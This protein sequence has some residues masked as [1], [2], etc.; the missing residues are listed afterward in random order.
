MIIIDHAAYEERT[1]ASNLGLPEYSYTFVRRSFR[2]ILE[3]LG[4]LHSV[5]DPARE[6][7]AIY[8]DARVRGEPC[9]FLSFNP[10][11]YVPLELEC[12]TVPVFAWEYDTI[13][14]EVWAANPQD[15]WR[16]PLL[17]CGSAIT[18]CQSSVRAVRAAMGDHYPIWSIPA[19][20]FSSKRRA[21]SAPGWPNAS[22]LVVDGAIVIDTSIVDVGIFHLD[23]VD[24][25][26]LKVLRKLRQRARANSTAT[27]I[28]LNEVVYTAI[29]NPADGRKNWIDLL[30]GFI[31][32]FRGN[33]GVTLIVKITQ[34]DMLAGL[35]PVLTFLARQGAFQCRIVVIQGML[36]DSAYAALI[37][38][39]SYIVN[40]SHGEGQCLPLMEFMSAGRPAIAPH[41]SAMTEYITP[42]NAFM[43]ESSSHLIKWP[44]DPRDARRC[45]H[46][47][48]NFT[49]L[50][51]AYQQSLRVIRDEPKRYREMSE[52][53]ATALEYYCS[54]EIV[55]RRM[56]EALAWITRQDVS[57]VGVLPPRRAD[58]NAGSVAARD[59]WMAG[60]S[61]E[62]GEIYHGFHIGEDD[63]VVVI[64]SEDDGLIDFCAKSG[65]VAIRHA[66]SEAK[67]L[68]AGCA[69]RVVC[70][71]TLDRVADP[72][73]LL[74]ALADA[75]RPGARYLLTAASP[76]R[77][78]LLRA[79]GLETPNVEALSREKLRDL[80]NGA[81][82]TTLH[83]DSDGFFRTLDDALSGPGT[84]GEAS[85]SWRSVWSQMLAASP[86]GE[87]QRAFDHALPGRHIIIAVKPIVPLPDP[88]GVRPP[89][90]WQE[91]WR[92]YE[93][94]SL[95]RADPFMQGVRD[96]VLAGWYNAETAE[97]APGFPI[98]E[99]DVVLDMGCGGGGLAGFCARQGAKLYLAD[100][101]P[102]TAT[103][104]RMAIRSQASQ[105]IETLVTNGNP[106][107]VPGRTFSHVMCTEVLEHVDDPEK[108]MTEIVRVG[109]PGALYLLTVPCA[110]VERIQ[111]AVGPKDYFRQ[112]NHVRAFADGELAA[113]AERAG[114]TIERR[115]SDGFFWSVGLLLIWTKGVRPGGRSPILDLWG[116]AW[117]AMLDQ[118]R[119]KAIKAALD[120]AL[121]KRQV[122]VARKSA[123]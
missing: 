31:W 112:P 101:G 109:R 34:A 107:P 14:T 38:A 86:D 23:T 100:I 104:A 90:R 85:D 114:L 16:V 123:D 110:A 47:I 96:A 36:S 87:I 45:H 27:P 74:S 115:L 25:L 72:A 12:P 93:A 121:P 92:P 75:G 94:A 111:E 56:A 55:T 116:T 122:I 9:A 88:P 33:P 13:P 1:I 102:F 52:A 20:I 50:V 6:V 58:A 77:V 71:D 15:D 59:F 28:D 76:A 103:S 7:D 11:R 97:L 108:I 8:N 119:G 54:D 17:Q 62:D 5:S 81:G 18:H 79:A 29:F 82:L 44:H 39:T 64:G 49:Q 35:M 91:Q 83:E 118:P 21:L 99:G 37:D 73:E 65:A 3:K 26:G 61:Y 89:R 2:P 117:S 105:P 106:L 78:A 120:A 48:I 66:A 53:A 68:L 98:S 10:P 63:N 80:V 24:V 60:W 84:E 40:T 51:E 95:D 57:L 46:Q 67:T 32:A 43:L 4:T 22:R 42:D 19:P 70:L 41:H 113:M 30:A 69:T